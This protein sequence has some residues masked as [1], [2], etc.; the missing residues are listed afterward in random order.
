MK[1]YKVLYFH[2]PN[3]DGMDL[4]PDV[5]V[6][7]LWPAN[8]FSV[9]VAGY[10]QRKLNFFE[11]SI[12]RLL[13][14]NL[15]NIEILCERTCLREGFIRLIL[16]RLRDQG[17]VNEFHLTA[18]GLDMLNKTMA[19][20][21]EIRNVFVFR[22]CL[23]KKFYPIIA[24][25]L[26]IKSGR[27]NEDGEIMFRTAKSSKKISASI[28]CQVCRCSP[29]TQADVMEIIHEFNALCVSQ[30]VDSNSIYRE[31]PEHIEIS[32][33][34]PDFVWFYSEARL[35]RK[36]HRI[37][38]SDP[39][40][41]HDSVIL[42]ENMNSDI[43]NRIAVEIKQRGVTVPDESYNKI[44]RF[45]S[46]EL[47]LS[48]LT[49]KNDKSDQLPNFSDS[50]RMERL[51]DY[52]YALE[53]AFKKMLNEYDYKKLVNTLREIDENTI[54]DVLMN[55]AIDMG[56]KPHYKGNLDPQI[57]D[58]KPWLKQD[59]SLEHFFLFSGSR[60][61]ECLS[62]EA[63]LRFWLGLAL[64]VDKKSSLISFRKLLNTDFI[65][66]VN[67]LIGFRNS[68]YHGDISEKLPTMTQLKLCLEITRDIVDCLLPDLNISSLACNEMSGLDLQTR[69]ERYYKAEA[70]LTHRL[71][72]AKMRKL[73][74][75]VREKLIQIKFHTIGKHKT[76]IFS[77][78]LIVDSL[79]FRI[80][81]A[82][83]LPE[84]PGNEVLQRAKSNF[85]QL[86]EIFWEINPRKLT[87]TIAGVPQSLRASLLCLMAF[88][89]KHKAFFNSNR[90]QYLEE[91]LHLRKHNW[92]EC[93]QSQPF[94]EIEKLGEQT[95]A[96]AT[97]II[98]EYHYE[99]E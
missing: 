56:L 48:P 95:I 42:G 11:V 79:M 15:C 17:Y 16:R 86:P 9:L 34:K 20:Q 97:A 89:E 71:G 39:F 93:V 2:K 12:L 64:L 65:L 92:Q 32:K 40:W 41:D 78:I 87:N 76:Y 81:R 85:P 70:D 96:F 31:S 19:E 75:D 35:G 49:D 27:S 54:K 72:Y 82:E 7:L 29:P 94:G 61:Q 47:L 5:S 13:N 52:C 22:D 88:C 69:D 99:E 23:S 43:L 62:G 21:P 59:F 1:D 73:P 10:P 80:T 4:F 28:A 6:P 46:L 66:F 50:D 91:I 18:L 60:L 37:Y 51:S 44:N 67:Y 25:R 3:W 26:E 14:L 90:L 8:V 53:Q 98:E 33:E 24:S 63:S 57:T 77:N 55:L 30:A 45:E 74:R 84:L 36:N 83:R 38:V 68:E 58:L